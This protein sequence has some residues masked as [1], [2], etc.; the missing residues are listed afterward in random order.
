LLK[1]WIDATNPAPN[2]EYIWRKDIDSAIEAF[3]SREKAVEIGMRR[4]HAC[5]LNRDY[6]GRTKCYEFANRHDITE[7]SISEE[8]VGSEDAARLKKY[9]EDVG[10][11][12]SCEITVHSRKG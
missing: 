6:A 11:L 9:L 10:R 5:F 12:E 4:G 8:L 7:I 3:A 1:L 2:N